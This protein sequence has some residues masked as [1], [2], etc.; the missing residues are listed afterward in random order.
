MIIAD[1]E[2][3]IDYLYY[4][5]IA[6]T[7]M[8]LIREKSCEPLSIGLH[9]DWGAGKS[10]A[11]LMIERAF[12]KED[13]T[14]CVRFNGWLFEGYDDAKAVLIETIV[15]ELLKQRSTFEKVKD[16]VSRRR[17]H[18]DHRE[19]DRRHHRSRARHRPGDRHPSRRARRAPGT[20]GAQRS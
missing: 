1:N 11:L 18:H 4:E 13:S 14:L 8:K 10:S 17:L 20:R 15:A 3:H 6:R 16:T 2:T 5:P 7:V 12:A 9:G 19:Q